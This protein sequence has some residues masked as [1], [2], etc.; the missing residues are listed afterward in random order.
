MSDK[1]QDK[2][3]I[4]KEEYESEVSRYQDY[5][6]FYEKAA[7]R[8][9]EFM[10]LFQGVYFAVISFS[11]LKKLQGALDLPRVFMVVFLLPLVFLFLS[12]SAAIYMMVMTKGRPDPTDSPSSVE[13]RK[14]KLKKW[15]DWCA[16]KHN[17]LRFSYIFMGAAF[18]FLFIAMGVYLVCL[19]GVE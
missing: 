1:V 6:S 9:V 15:E 8:V 2:L 16:R 12:M 10:T 17:A 19:P 11:D 5:I 14:E 4:L 3:L 18:L 7:Q 13:E